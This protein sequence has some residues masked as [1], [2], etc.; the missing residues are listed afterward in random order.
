MSNICKVCKQGFTSPRGLQIHLNHS[1]A[2]VVLWNKVEDNDSSS[3]S[4]EAYSDDIN[5]D[6]LFDHPDNDVDNDSDDTN[7]FNNNKKSDVGNNVDLNYELINQHEIN[8]EA[9]YGGT[10]MNAQDY[11]SGVELIQ[12]LRK[13]KAPLYLYNN[14]QRWATQS[15]LNLGV[16]FRKERDYTS[17]D[18]LLKY[19]D[20]RFNMHSLK[21]IVTK[22]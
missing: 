14:I 20:R 4:S 1:Q 21:P 9:D 18:T 19:I 17:C 8:V 10:I 13:A 12:M 22:V 5:F 2:C 3:D 16:D 15:A 6:T 11:K 7:N